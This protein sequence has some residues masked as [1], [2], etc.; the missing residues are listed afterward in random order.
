[1]REVLSAL[2]R[3]TPVHIHIA[4]QQAEVDECVAVR[5]ARPVE[6]LLD[7]AEVDQHWT[8]VHA[9]H[10]NAAE[11]SGIAQSQAVVAIC[12]TTEANL[13]D[14]LFPLRDYLN[15]GGRWGVGSDSH[16]SVSPVEEG[17]GR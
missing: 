5:G 4:E 12:T 10:L 13:G 9:T 11:V 2:P 14:G 7:N 1:M 3:Q 16:V 17:G 6:W 15:A 8:L